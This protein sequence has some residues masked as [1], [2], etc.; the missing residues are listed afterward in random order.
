MN[1]S[2]SRPLSLGFQ[3]MKK[4]LFQPFD[5]NKWL[6][7]GFTAW[8]A[9]L[10]DC[11]GGSS[12]SHHSYKYDS[13]N[14]DE[15]FNFPQTAGD[16]I[17]T[18]PLW[19]NL[20]LVGILLLIVLISVFIWVSSRGKFMFLHNVAQNKSDVSYP[21]HE[22]RNE[23]NSLFL[24]E[25]F[26]GWL[27]VGLFGFFLFY[28]F[29]SAKELYYGD[30]TNPAIFMAVGQMVLLLIAYLLTIGFTALFLKDF[31][32]PIMY[33]NRIGVLQAWGKFLALF[34]QRF[35]AFIGYGLFIFILSFGVGIAVIFLALITC[36]IALFL[37]AIPYIGTVILLPVS[38]TYRA[39]SLEFLAQFGPDFNVLAPDEDEVL[40][41]IE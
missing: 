22:Y 15:L 31:V 35:F 32:V 24:F 13:N 2:Y 30:Y 27:S 38:Y 25:F 23:G 29:T 21:W 5:L 6:R 7:I 18:H 4:A 16:W 10:A 19:A 26:F 9:G 36:C 34:G 40:P 14:L 8:L 33:K 17:S 1:I 41:I 28:C 11:E 20:I 12:G 37:L 39:L 3:R